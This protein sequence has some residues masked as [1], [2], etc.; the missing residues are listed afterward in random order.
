MRY[1]TGS[2]LAHTDERYIE[3]ALTDH[4]IKQFYDVYNELGFGFLESVYEEAL[5]RALR[6]AGMRI[7]R[8]APVPVNFRGECIAEF[9]ADLL[10]DGKVIVELKAARTIEPGHEAQLLNYL[11]ATDLQVGLLLNFGP[12]PQVRRLVFSN[13]R[14]ISVQQRESA[15]TCSFSVARN[16]R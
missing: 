4:I 9:K 8:Q 10:V 15:A 12:H 2:V 5:S 1:F 6:A 16:Q 3:S 14:K 11:R 7:A 13:Q